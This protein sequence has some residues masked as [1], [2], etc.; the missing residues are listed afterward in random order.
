MLIPFVHSGLEDNK[1]LYCCTAIKDKKLDDDIDD[2]FDEEIIVCTF[3]STFISLNFLTFPALSNHVSLLI[4][5]VSSTSMMI[6][7]NFLFP[8]L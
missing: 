1:D 6:V 4:K 7:Y 2:C 3:Y 8:S 5:R